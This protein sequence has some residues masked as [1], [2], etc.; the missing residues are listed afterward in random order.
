MAPANTKHLYNIYTMLDQRQTQKNCIRFKQCWTNVE[1]IEPSLY[2]C[3]KNVLCLLGHAEWYMQHM[4]RKNTWRWPDVG[5][6]LAHRL[7]H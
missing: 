1:D 6:I 5:L 7:R 4:P 2:K 3:Y